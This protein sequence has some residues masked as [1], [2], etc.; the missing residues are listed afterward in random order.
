[1][2]TVY[3]DASAAVKLLLKESE[4][5]AL[6]AYLA[7]HPARASSALMRAELLRVARRVDIDSVGDARGVLAKFVL[8]EIDDEVLDRAGEIAPHTLRT[9]NAI[10]VATATLLGP[11]LEAVVTY[12][13]RMVEAAKLYGLP[14]VSPA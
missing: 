3:L 7:H 2:A 11:D 9:L 13:R 6:R 5:T 14:V 4:S 10:H 1:V 8:R 12:D